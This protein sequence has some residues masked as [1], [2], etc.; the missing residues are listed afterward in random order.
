MMSDCCYF[1]LVRIELK[2]AL[3]TIWILRGV[4]VSMFESSAVDCEF[5]PRSGQTTAY[6]MCICCCSTKHATVL[7]QNPKFGIV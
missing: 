6:K 2:L 5:E 4:M 1:T 3:Y 7:N